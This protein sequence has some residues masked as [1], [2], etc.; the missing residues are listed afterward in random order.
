MDGQQ[1]RRDTR[2][3]TMPAIRVVATSADG[4]T[5]EYPSIAEASQTLSDVNMKF[6]TRLNHIRLALDSGATLDARTWTRKAVADGGEQLPAAVA[7]PVPVVQAP[8]EGKFIFPDH[9]DELFR[10]KTIRWVDAP[11]RFRASDVMG[12]IGGLSNLSISLRALIV[13]QPVF[14]AAHTDSHRFYGQGNQPA[15]VLPIDATLEFIALLHGPTVRAFRL[16]TLAWFATAIRGE[17]MVPQP[18]PM[19]TFTSKLKV[20]RTRV[21]APGES[22]T[23]TNVNAASLS[24]A[25]ESAYT[26]VHTRVRVAKAIVTGEEFMGFTWR[27]A[28]AENPR[29]RMVTLC[30]GVVVPADGEGAA[31]AV[32]E[33]GAAVVAAEQEDAEAE[34]GAGEGVEMET[35]GEGVETQGEQGEDAGDEVAVAVTEEAAPADVVTPVSTGN[36]LV[37]SMVAEHGGQIIAEMRTSDGFVNATK[38]CTAG[39]KKWYDYIRGDDTKKFM[40]AFKAGYPALKNLVISQRGGNHA[41]TWVHPQVAVHLASWIS[42]AFAV[43]VTRLVTRYTGGQVT[44]AESEAASVALGNRVTVVA[45]AL[46][47]LT[48]TPQ[49][50]R[51]MLRSGQLSAGDIIKGLGLCRQDEDIALELV[52][53]QKRMVVSPF[54]ESHVM[55]LCITDI[56]LPGMPDRL[57]LKIGYSADFVNRLQYL[58]GEYRCGM[59]LLCGLVPVRNEQFE[60]NFHRLLDGRFPHLVC[61]MRI[62]SVEKDELY[63]CDRGVLNEFF[64]LAG[65]TPPVVCGPS[66]ALSLSVEETKRAE[67]EFEMLKFRVAHSLPV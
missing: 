17:M 41:G 9:V 46:P 40:A 52:E 55:Y 15:L 27:N 23:F 48:R 34:E 60:K 45:D 61:N 63:L 8:R 42:P 56:K 59:M 2:D 66:L 24:V 62:G 10:G 7:L 58:L 36:N 39:G 35:E 20:I 43:A 18:P 5:V 6:K 3:T 67:I 22:V 57:V 32:A 11:V 30:G 49:E 47:T 19:P 31:A 28:P 64:A 16:T 25:A 38:M 26:P 50:V 51:V 29:R 1:G 13:A 44:T 4:S 65:S 21:A 53:G 33:E 14:F 54:M 37:D 12:V